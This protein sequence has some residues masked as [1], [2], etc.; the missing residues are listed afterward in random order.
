MPETKRPARLWL[1]PLL[2]LLAIRATG[3]FQLE[4]P[5]AIGPAF[6]AGLGLD[7]AQIGMLMGAFMLPGIFITVAAG[8]LA[9][10]IGDRKVLL[11]GML[12]MAAG[13]VLA[14]VAPGFP[15][16][17]AGRMLSGI[18][19]VAML[20]LVLKMTADR[21][22]GPM[23]STATSIVIVSWPIG[24]ALSLQ[25]LGTLA[26]TGDWRVL[27]LAS[28]LPALAATLLIPLVGQALP[29]S[30][31]AGG[32]ET[33]PVRWQMIVAATMC[34]AALNAGTA[35]M[36]GF[37]Q[38]YLASIGF[39]TASAAN[40]ASLCSWA[41]AVATPFGGLIADRLIGR[42]QAVVLGTLAT[43]AMFLLIPLTSGHPVS[44]ILLGV[45]I[46][47]MPGAL[48]AQL[49][50]ATP[51][52]ARARVFGWYSAGSYLAITLIPWLAGA[53]H[54]A[55]GD[56]RAPVALGAAIMLASLPAYAWFR[57]AARH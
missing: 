54:D 24:F 37:L 7:H 53:L 14:A 23:L 18:G 26:A 36:A 9:R 55:S 48:T 16:L 28:G 44:F 50:A 47:L 51:Q 5:A 15:V 2:A 40:R 39:D 6:T 3:S 22:A 32:A 29:M 17:L 1:P 12:L 19:G 31:S 46:A 52:A 41:F 10:R 8:L 21:F 57:R 25:V 27:M 45:S 33:R 56:A 35:I 11:G 20:M 4:A 49:G 43:A 13:A 34:W 42:T 38:G 30:A